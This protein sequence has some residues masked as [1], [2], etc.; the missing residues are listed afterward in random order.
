MAEVSVGH[1]ANDIL[2]SP[3]PGFTPKSSLDFL[4]KR[5]FCF[6]VKFPNL[7]Q[8]ILSSSEHGNPSFLAQILECAFA[9]LIWDISNKMRMGTSRNPGMPEQHFMI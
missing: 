4:S 6:Q 8:H 3:L 5:P 2:P 7:D 9:T 1:Q